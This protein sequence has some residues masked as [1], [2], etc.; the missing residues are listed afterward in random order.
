MIGNR[1]D[2]DLWRDLKD[3]KAARDA[4]YVAGQI[5]AATYE[6][7]LRGYGYLP[8]EAATERGLLDMQK[9]YR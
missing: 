1:T 5:G 8:K 3:R 4:E 7:S 9:R 6:V 2:P